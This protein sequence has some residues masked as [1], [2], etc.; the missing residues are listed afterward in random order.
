MNLSKIRL[1]KLVITFFLLYTAIKLY[2]E[3]SNIKYYISL[4]PDKLWIYSLIIPILS[5]YILSIRWFFL[6]R[7]LKYKIS[8]FDSLKVYLAGL[9]F[10]AAPARS[11]EAIRSLWLSN[12]HSIPIKIGIGITINERVTDLISA[13]IL[14]IWSTNNI[15]LL[16]VL[17]LFLFTIIYTARSYKILSIVNT[18]LKKL[19]I[20]LIRFMPFISKHRGRTGFK[21]KLYKIL[22]GIKEIN[23]PTPVIIATFL[24]IIAWLLEALLMYFVFNSLNVNLSYKQSTLIRTAMGIGGAL[25]IFPAGLLTSESTSIGLAVALGSGKVEAL[26]STLFTR[27]YTL[28][29]PSLIGLISMNSQKDLNFKSNKKFY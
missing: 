22:S 23:K 28:L 15:K 4:V 19:S 17:I 26:A 18:T 10:M 29:I 12:R 20:F 1:L 8:Y 7:F 14:I 16:I 9:T 13:L 25:S 27:I 11:G 5:H 3:F 21:S 6:I 24:C 2:P